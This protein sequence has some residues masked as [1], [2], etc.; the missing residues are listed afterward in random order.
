MSTNLPD[1]TTAP[2]AI[3]VYFEWTITVRLPNHISRSTLI[4]LVKGIWLANCVG[5]HNYKFFVLLLFYCTLVC[6]GVGLSTVPVYTSLVRLT[7][8]TNTGNTYPQPTHSQIGPNLHPLLYLV[9]YSC[10]GLAII[11]APFTSF[12]FFL[13]SLNRTTLEWIGLMTGFYTYRVRNETKT[14]DSLYPTL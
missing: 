4:G 8:V 7:V 11:S 10:L 2:F 13:I 5:E 6:G 1:P 14:F 9:K 3:A 12:H